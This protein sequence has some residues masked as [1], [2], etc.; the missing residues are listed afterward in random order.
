MRNLLRTIFFLSA[1]SPVLFS[2][3]YVR[4]DIYGF[5]SEV[6]QLI[7]VGMLGSMIPFLVI[8]LT[9]RVAEQMPFEAK[10][11][12]SNDFMLLM[13]IASY[14]IPIVARASE[15]NFVKTSIL[16]ASLFVVLWLISF[17]PTHPVLRI[18]KYRFYKV[19]SSSGV[20]YTLV[21]SKEI[22]DPKNVKKVRKISNSML[23]G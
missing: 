10:K 4:Y 9:T 21:S 7:I 22:L 17:L 15:L 5:Q 23:L 1:F 11:I 13:F 19:E 20:I 14:F 16:T 2:L 12:E 8:G 6:W 18:F 3:A